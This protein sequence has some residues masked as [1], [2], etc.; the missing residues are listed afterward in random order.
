MASVARVV[1]S[2]DWHQGDAH[3]NFKDSLPTFLENL[4]RYGVR[5]KTVVHISR[6]E[7]IF[8]KFLPSSFD[9]AFLDGYHDVV[10]VSKDIDLIYPLIR[11][12]GLFAFHDYGVARYGVTD[13]VTSL[14]ERRRLKVDGVVDTLA[15]ITVF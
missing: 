15:W 10:D 11:R 8:P 3:A 4:K 14:V 5:Q 12:G 6:F 2:V 9:L 7:E 1:H 13:A